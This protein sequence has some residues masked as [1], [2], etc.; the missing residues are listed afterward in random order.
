MDFERPTLQQRFRHFTG[1]PVD[2]DL[3]PFRDL[4]AG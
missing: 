4:V 3:R 1:Q 2:F